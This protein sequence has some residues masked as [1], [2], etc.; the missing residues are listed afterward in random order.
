MRAG[1]RLLKDLEIAASRALLILHPRNLEPAAAGPAIIVAVYRPG[2]R[3]VHNV[4]P[5]FS[6]PLHQHVSSH[7]KERVT[8]KSK[9]LKFRAAAKIT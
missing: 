2:G 5:K 8:A 6:Q 1:D 7:M 4:A 3:V 9:V